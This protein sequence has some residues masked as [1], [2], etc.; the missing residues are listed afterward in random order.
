MELGP[1]YFLRLGMVS[2]PPE[3]R[4]NRASAVNV[5]NGFEGRDPDFAVFAAIK[6]GFLCR[7]KLA[8]GLLFFL[9]NSSV[10]KRSW[11]VFALVFAIL[12]ID[13][14]LKIYVKT[15]FEY[16]E[17][18]LLGGAS[19]AMLKFVENDGMAFGLSLGGE[20]GKLALSIFRL[21]AVGLLIFYIKRLL[22]TRAPQ[23]F[24]LCI[25]LIL[26]GAVGN[27]LDS[28]F[29]GMLF[30]ESHFHGGLATFATVEAPGYE[31]FL[32]GKVVD[33]FHFPLFSFSIP[34]SWPFLKGE[35]FSFFSFIFNVADAAI[36]CGVLTILFFQRQFF[37]DQETVFGDKPAAD[38][39]LLENENGEEMA[40]NSAAEPAEN[41]ATEPI[42]KI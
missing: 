34:E 38:S 30:T 15:H 37:K 31:R 1:G 33:M 18:Y 3:E 23:G 36:T 7:L 14:A 29:Y 11:Q 13:Q 6:F 42:E 26:A 20:Y 39:T 4:K 16:G 19:W 41:S 17:E 22:E 27:I 9:K 32:F 8:S 2:T 28:M 5:V 24:V 10:L 12:F 40:E 35:E 21:V 25:G